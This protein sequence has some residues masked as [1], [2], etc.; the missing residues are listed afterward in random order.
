MGD[1]GASSGNEAGQTDSGENV[2]ASGAGGS[3]VP[4]KEGI[5]TYNV[6]TIETAR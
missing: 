2:K 5:T 3:N 1:T 4:D 6:E